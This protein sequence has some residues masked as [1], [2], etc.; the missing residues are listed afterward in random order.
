MN[1]MK[2]GDIFRWS[3]KEPIESYAYHCKSRI[4]I[5][6]GERLVDTFWGYGDNT[7][8]AEED[9]IDKLNLVYVENMSN[10]E[11]INEY[12][13]KN[14]DPEDIINLNHSNSSEGN[15]YKKSKA[16]YSKTAMLGYVEDEILE[17]KRQMENAERM[18]MLLE[19]QQKEIETGT[20]LTKV[21][22]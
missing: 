5:F 8:W 22:L 13:I 20:D 12:E 19:K 7:Y 17:K 10:L 1:K 11:C 4:A 3:Y 16:I 21:Y 6:N 14:Y 18:I 2:E 15:V 9:A